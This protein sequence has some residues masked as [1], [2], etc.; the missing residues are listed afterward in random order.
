MPKMVIMVIMV[1]MVLYHIL[2]YIVGG[3]PSLALS[4]EHPLSNYY[5]NCLFIMKS[6]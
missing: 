3:S 1:I 5:L 6:S 2:H 4:S